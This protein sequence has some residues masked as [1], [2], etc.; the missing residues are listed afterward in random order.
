[1]FSW[2]LAFFL[3][4]SSTTSGTATNV[5]L[6][7]G[8]VAS[9]GRVEIFHDGKWGT[10]CDDKWGIS[11]AQ[12][13][14][15]QL[16]YVYA[17]KATVE[18]TFGGGSD[19]TW[20]DGVECTGTEETLDQCRFEGWGR[21][22]C[23]HSEDAGAVCSNGKCPALYKLDLTYLSPGTDLP[24][25]RLV[26]GSSPAEGRIEV[27]YDNAWGAICTDG[28]TFLNSRVVCRQLGYK[29]ANTTQ[30]SLSL[31]RIWMDDCA[32]EGTE[33]SIYNCSFRGWGVQDCMSAED[34]GVS[35][36]ETS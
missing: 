35:C 26:D 3:L 20:M 8:A 6:V 2:S 24:P 7:G 29:D 1:M 14:C 27:F 18:S 25:L 36:C 28:W 30:F 15:K 17:T 22:N 31:R 5:R 23:D 34:V 11:D 10:V 13:V 33:N 16:G 12:V 21:E 19:P 9:E 32:C 4:T